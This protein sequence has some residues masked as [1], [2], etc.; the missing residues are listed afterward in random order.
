MEDF[1]NILSYDEKKGQN[2]HPNYLI[3][4]FREVVFDFGL[5]DIY[6]GGLFL[7]MGKKQGFTHWNPGKA[8]LS[9]GNFKL[10][11][12]QIVVYLTLSLVG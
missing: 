6:L 7:Y 11:L 3:T 9:F 4:G 2:S 1:N 8:W 12:S 5:N 10:I